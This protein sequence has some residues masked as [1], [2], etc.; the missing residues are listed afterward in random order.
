MMNLAVLKLVRFFHL[1][2]KEK[3]NTLRQIGFIE[4]S[5]MFDA[6][7]Y[8]KQ[9][10]Q[11]KKSKINPIEH[12]VKIGWKDGC[13]PNNHFDN[14]KYLQAY[15]ELY[16]KNLS[17]LFHYIR[18]NP[19]ILKQAKYKKSKWININKILRKYDKK[20]E[21]YKLIAQ[22]K[23]FDKR[24][25]L[26]QYPDVAKAGVDPVEHYLRKGWRE[27][28]NP[29][30]KFSTE[31][32]YSNNPDV[33]AANVNPLLH[34]E[35]CGRKE[36]RI[37]EKINLYHAY[38]WW[39]K[40]LRQLGRII[41]HK[42]I[43]QNKKAKI[44]VHLHMFYAQAWS[45]IKEYLQNMECYNY[46]L[47]ITGNQEFMHS[48]TAR[49]IKEYKE[50]TRFI[51]CIDKGFDIGPFMQAIQET[52]LNRYH[53]IYHLHSKG[54]VYGRGR[55]T[56][57]RMFVKTSWFRQLFSGCMGVFNVHRGIDVLMH[58][59]SYG[60]IGANNLVFNDTPE[61]QRVVKEYAHRLKIEV[62][63]EYKFIGG[64][65]FGAKSKI[66]QQV[67]KIKLDINSFDY[68]KRNIFTLAHAMERII[69]II[70]QNMGYQ[71]YPLSVR[72]NNH[73]RFVK[74]HLKKI[75][76]K[77]FI[78][79]QKLLPLGVSELKS[80]NM[81]IVSGLHCTFYKGLYQNKEIFIKWGGDAEVAANEITM[82]QCFYK[83]L[84][85]YVPQILIAD[86]EAPFIITPYLQGYNVEELQNLGMYEKEKQLILKELKEI[87]EKLKNSKLIHRD[88]R[89]A[90]L[91]MA[92]NNLYLLDY[93]FATIINLDSTLQELDYVKKHPNIA[94][95]LGDVYRE[96]ATTWNDAFS[97][98]L[99]IKEIK[100]V[101]AIDNTDRKNK[102]RK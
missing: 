39:Y 81:D 2:D 76:D 41:Y 16:E 47:I 25:Y 96:S 17:P 44:L 24:W 61:R 64:S 60:I 10:P 83:I 92:N 20:S 42:E 71:I 13:N 51:P 82:Q 58:N 5:D 101:K 23:Y 84:G 87:K 6:T 7:Y 27:N 46:D 40:I 31:M 73:T 9:N 18:E 77:E 93:Q 4:K 26:K 21:N 19:S 29:S 68:S 79:A 37:I 80:L 94:R 69:A 63:D 57:K 66:L 14:D 49:E 102:K 72:Y 34:Y 67:K 91:F 45:E 100:E 74:Q 28:R 97:I 62:P 55:I 56:Y 36:G 59:D 52:D 12:Y 53:I 11:L 48:S 50:N 35:R 98:D 95:D 88:I 33:K 65:C 1:I 38:G 85:K 54:A 3:Y 32:Y 22:S 30:K 8:F 15:P 89:P 43:E 99:I 78:I 86:K 90:N 75:A 70:G